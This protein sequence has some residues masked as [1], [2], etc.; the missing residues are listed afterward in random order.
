MTQY[1]NIAQTTSQAQVSN[2]TLNLNISL[3]V[4]HFLGKN[5]TC[6]VERPQHFGIQLAIFDNFF[7]GGT[8]LLKVD[9]HLPI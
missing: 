1:E 9:C 5:T 6:Q 8:V 2:T 7:Q 3:S 4:Q